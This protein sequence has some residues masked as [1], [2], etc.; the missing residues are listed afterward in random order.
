MNAKDLAREVV[1]VTW[2]VLQTLTSSLKFWRMEDLAGGLDLPPVD[3][4]ADWSA[5]VARIR[6]E[7]ASDA[8][9]DAERV[10]RVLYLVDML[11]DRVRAAAEGPAGFEIA[12]WMRPMVALTLLMMASKEKK[13]WLEKGLVLGAAAMLLLDVRV[14][15]SLLGASPVARS[16]QGLWALIEEYATDEAKAAAALVGLEA[17]I[18]WLV[19]TFFR[20]ETL[21]ASRRLYTGFDVPAYEPPPASTPG[22]PPTVDP[23]AVARES[24]R[25]TVAIE[26]NW[27]DGGLAPARYQ[28]FDPP[29]PVTPLPTVGFRTTIVPVPPSS[30]FDPNDSSR[31]P[32]VHVS[33]GGDLAKTWHIGDDSLVGSVSGDAGLL[34]P[35]PRLTVTPHGWWMPD[36][37]FRWDTSGSV[38][39][40]TGAVEAL[41]RYTT[42]QRDRAEP[43]PEGVSLTV[44]RFGVEARVSVDAARATGTSALG[45]ISAR[46]DL[47]GATLTI[48]RI[49]G[50]GAVLPNGASATFDVGV[51]VNYP[52]G[53]ALEFGFRGA[54]G[55]ELV[56][57]LQHTLGGDDARIG[58]RQVRIKAHAGRAGDS[59]NAPGRMALEIT[60]DF[61]A[62]VRAW[63]LSID[64]VGVA[65]SVGGAEHGD[66]NLMGVVDAGWA[67]AWPTR[68]GITCDCAAFHGGGFAAYEPE[69][70][71]WSGG[72]E[73]TA[74]KATLRALFLC[75]PTTGGHHSWLALAN[76]TFPSPCWLV[77]KGVGVLVGWRRTTDPQALL[78]AVAAGDLTAV[79]FPDDIAARGP[80][81]LAT[82][83]RL[84]PAAAGG[85][86]AGLFLRFAAHDDNARVDLGVV[87]DGD[88]HAYLL[89]RVL[90]GLPS[91]DEPLVRIEVAALGLWDR[92]RDEYEIRAAL[93]NSRALGGEMTGEALLFSGDPDRDDGR[94][95]RVRLLSIGGFHPKYAAPGPNV[96]VP[97][98][99]ALLIEKGDHL[100]LECQGY[101]AI[102]PGALHAGIESSLVARFAGF[103][104]RGNL[105]F[106]AL[107]SAQL[108]FV[109]AI[110]VGVALYLGSRQLL[111]A[112]FEGEFGIVVEDQFPTT[113]LRG[114]ATISLWFFDYETPRFTLR[115]GRGGATATASRDP[116]DRLYEA[117]LDHGSWDTGGTPGLLVRPGPRPGLWTSPSA[118]LRLSQGVVPLGVPITHLNGAA[119]PAPQTLTVEVVR[120]AAA[121]W[122]TA[123]VDAEFAPGLFFALTDEEKL[124][125]RGFEALPG[126]VEVVRPLVAGASVTTTLD[127]E[128]LVIDSANPPEPARAGAL[129]PAVQVMAATLDPHQLDAQHYPPRRTP[130]VRA[131]R[132]AVIDGRGDVIAAD[133]GFAAALG[134]ARLGTQLEVVPMREVA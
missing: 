42:G 125:A 131:D 62:G 8:L 82:L 86:V 68:L 101:F 20:D 85:W 126:G 104:I 66:G 97:A 34:L 28:A 29:S 128:D 25:W 33:I 31:R 122:T 50:L 133:H 88:Q 116:A 9:G 39:E 69:T 22:A 91:L 54:A 6:G 64:G 5:A 79:L 46:A 32:H 35:I 23:L 120:P 127:C 106:D 123:P 89:A 80:A 77:P 65:V 26:N 99:M 112:S 76:V 27:E 74:G 53:G 134:R 60:G 75:E 18:E 16:E 17:T 1:N 98:R 41:L 7:L 71:R 11:T 113:Y 95:E 90:V 4:G 58:V 55:G 118:P 48:G 67:M 52:I 111:G 43:D 13:H 19:R 115:L 15:E 107:L 105:G 73:F 130:R 81:Y 94:R 92:A 78:A 103:G 51:L 49:P 70:G 47:E 121:A 108:E 57:P 84:L 45:V 14:Q 109:V 21:L 119:L 37:D 56:L 129:E 36:W 110:R 63:N 102:T 87:F 117:V 30:R 2:D 59:A 3:L 24:A 100:R 72:G 12:A 93:V 38:V 44:D 40:V 124:A 83:G 10:A 96:R 61:I 132:F 114:R